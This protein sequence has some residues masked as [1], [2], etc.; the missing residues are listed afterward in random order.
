MARGDKTQK[1]PSDE[2]DVAPSATRSKRSG[3]ASEKIKHQGEIFALLDTPRTSCFL[4][5]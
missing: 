4:R 2:E 1:L 5:E 3:T